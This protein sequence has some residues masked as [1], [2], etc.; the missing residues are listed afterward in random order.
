LY[1]WCVCV[2]L[3]VCLPVV[4]MCVWCLR[5]NLKVKMEWKPHLTSHFPAGRT[6]GLSV[7]S[8]SFPSSCFL[9][10]LA[11]ALECLFH[12][13][14]LACMCST[15]VVSSGLLR[16]ARCARC[17][18]WSLFSGKSQP[19]KNRNL[20]RLISNL[21]RLNCSSERNSVHFFL[22]VFTLLQL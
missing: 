16:N 13:F 18:G 12:L 2:C 22:T 5:R 21:S 4:C 15:Q 19:A 14:A 1:T 11:R 20:S 9:P 3:C 10:V 17:P 8:C 6:R 7:S